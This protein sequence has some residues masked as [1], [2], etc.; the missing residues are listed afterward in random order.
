MSTAK[1]YALILI[2]DLW[3]WYLVYLILR[4]LSS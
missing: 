1:K 2:I 3:L 4:F